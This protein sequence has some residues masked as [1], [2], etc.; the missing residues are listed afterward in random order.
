V[1]ERGINTGQNSEENTEKKFK[2]SGGTFFVRHR[3]ATHSGAESL[4]WIC[5]GWCN[6]IVLGYSYTTNASLPVV[7]RQVATVRPHSLVQCP[8]L[9]DKLCRAMALA[10]S[11]AGACA[12]DGLPPLLGTCMR[13]DVKLGRPNPS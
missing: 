10:G 2:F 5:I 11:P 12:A 6:K 8:L 4:I 7:W 13:Q 3:T 1:L 9:S